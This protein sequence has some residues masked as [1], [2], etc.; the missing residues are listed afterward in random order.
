M[1]VASSTKRLKIGANVS[2]RG[3]RIG[4]SSPLSQNSPV[5]LLSYIFSKVQRKYRHRSRED[6][7]WIG[8][9]HVCRRW[10]GVALDSPILWVYIPFHC[11]K[12]VSEM[13]KRSKSTTLKIELN[14]KSCIQSRLSAVREFLVV[15]LSRIQSI[16]LYHPAPKKVFLQALFQDLPAHSARC[17]ERLN[18]RDSLVYPRD[19]NAMALIERLLDG[20]PRL[21]RLRMRCAMDWSSKILTDLTHLTLHHE[22]GTV[23]QTTHSEFIEVLARM[24]ALRKLHLHNVPLPAPPTEKLSSQSSNIIHLPQLQS[25]LLF[26]SPPVVC[27]VLRHISFPGATRFRLTLE[28]SMASDVAVIS[29]LFRGRY[30]STNVAIKWPLAR[31]LNLTVDD[32]EAHMTAWSHSSQHTI[33]HGRLSL[34][35]DEDSFLELNLLWSFRS[36]TP[37]GEEIKAQ[38]ILEMCSALPFRSLTMLSVISEVELAGINAESLAEALGRQPEV[39]SVRVEGPDP[40]GIPRNPRCRGADGG[41]LKSNNK[42]PLSS[43]S[44]DIWRKIQEKLALGSSF[45]K[46]FDPEK[47]TPDEIETRRPQTMFLPFRK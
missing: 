41:F 20:P 27:N 7:G 21:R 6:L 26:G 29:S 24:P 37:N 38:A 42:P 44:F 43:L 17:I 33:R 28:V 1:R 30:M 40:Q 47:T 23:T 36:S 45:T 11:P 19:S 15:H 22:G 31:S 18:L 12:W 13:T 2:E 39:Q 35:D 10:R 14:S 32:D 9:T 16:E 34:P 5:E 25:I 3:S 8:V 4:T 46:Y